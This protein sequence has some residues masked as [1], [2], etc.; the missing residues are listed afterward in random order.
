VSDTTRD[1]LALATSLLA[2]MRG[3]SGPGVD[4]NL[5]PHLKEAMREIMRSFNEAGVSRLRMR[6]DVN[7][8]VG[9]T[10]LTSSSS[11]ALPTDFLEPIRLWERLTS[12]TYLDFVQM[13]KVRDALPQNEPQS[14]NLIWWEWRNAALYFVGSTQAVTIRIDYYADVT[15]LL[16][17]GDAVPIDD[18]NGPLGYLTAAGYAISF[19][20]GLS[21]TLKAEGNRKLSTVINL[22]T[23]VKQERPARAYRR[24]F[25]IPY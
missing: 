10:A 8:T 13:V 23:H 6:A 19:D 3:G 7:L 15:A 20:A 2:G 25:G 1:A 4:S 12:G 16:D 24:R 11:P 22:D 14:T 21:E 9:Q 5:E 18:I 17:Y